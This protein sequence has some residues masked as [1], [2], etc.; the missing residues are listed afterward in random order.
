MPA[1]TPYGVL[2]AA[3]LLAVTSFPARCATPSSLEQA[4]SRPCS[5]RR[6]RGAAHRLVQALA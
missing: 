4:Y 5:R 2:V 1:R 6:I 3:L